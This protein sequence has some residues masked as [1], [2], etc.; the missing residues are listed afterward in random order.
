MSIPNFNII[1]ELQ[2]HIR[3]HS[4]KQKYMRKDDTQYLIFTYIYIFFLK[5]VYY[6]PFN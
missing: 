1:K 2:T 6:G 4:Q 5:V 3:K